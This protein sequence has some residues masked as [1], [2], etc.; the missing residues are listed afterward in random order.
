MIGK[1]QGIVDFTDKDSAIIMAGN[2]GYLVHTPD[3][4]QRGDTVNLW[5]ETVVREDSIRLF[6][7]K[8]FEGK[9][10]FNK[11]T[12]VSGWG[13]KGAMSIQSELK[14]DVLISAIVTGDAK[15][16]TAAPGIG[17]KMAEKIIL[18]LKGKHIDNNINL[19]DNSS[20]TN[21]VLADLLSVLENLGYKRIEVAEIAQKLIKEN[22]DTGVETLL[23]KALK[24]ISKK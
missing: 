12:S 21:S 23:P 11:L 6:G 18:E 13:P 16:I 15:T 20:G 19:G 1:L 10:L 17:K 14:P 24:E 8:S 7:F 2:V 22:S 5:I 3:Y 9:D 4:L